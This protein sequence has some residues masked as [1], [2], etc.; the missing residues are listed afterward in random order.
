MK[1]DT[2]LRLGRKIEKLNNMLLVLSIRVEENLHLALK[3]LDRRDEALAKQ[4]IDGDLEIDLAEVDLEEECLEVLALHQPVAKDLRHIVAALKINKD[5][6]RAG[7]YAA[8]IARIARDF[9]RGSWIIRIPK[10]YFLMARKT[11]GMLRQSLEAFVNKSSEDAYEVL[12]KDDEVDRMRRSLHAEFE[13]KLRE[14]VELVTPLARL[15]LLARH[16]ERL[17]DL[18]TNIAEEVIYD[19]TGDIVRHGRK[20]AEA[21]QK[22]REQSTNPVDEDSVQLSGLFNLP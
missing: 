13:A 18:A 10:D 6:E 17:A 3:A 20:I 8:N 16:L 1:S 15:F 19:V 11:Q 5:L 7:D 4:V 12:S 9:C 14:D 21:K 2:R 22:K